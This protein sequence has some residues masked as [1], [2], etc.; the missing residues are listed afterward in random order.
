MKYSKYKTINFHRLK[1]KVCMSNMSLT[2][3]KDLEK[4]LMNLKFLMALPNNN[5]DKELERLQHLL[6]SQI[7][8]ILSIQMDLSPQQQLQYLIKSNY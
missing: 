1:I 5:Q 3:L 6:K 7:I 2:V 8:K 4:L